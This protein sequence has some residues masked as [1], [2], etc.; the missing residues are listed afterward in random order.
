MTSLKELTDHE[1]SQ[2]TA[3]NWRPEIEIVWGMDTPEK[4][5][6]WDGFEP[7]EFKMTPGQKWQITT[8]TN[9]IFNSPPTYYL[10]LPGSQGAG[11]TIS[12]LLWAIAACQKGFLSP[13]TN[14]YEGWDHV[15]VAQTKEKL[16]RSLIKW[17]KDMMQD[18]G[19][20]DRRRW[21]ATNRIYTFENGSRMLFVSTDNYQK[22]MGERYHSFY[23]NELPG[24]ECETF[25]ALSGRGIVKCIA[26][27]NPKS[28]FWYEYEW[29]PKHD[30]YTEMRLAYFG[31]EMLYIVNTEEVK[32]LETM[33]V[34]DPGRYRTM[35]L[36]L[37]GATSQ[38]I[39][40][41]DPAEK[42]KDAKLICRGLDF[43][44]EAPMALINIYYKG[45]VYYVEEEIYLTSYALTDLCQYIRGLPGA[46]NVPIVCDSKRPEEI[47]VLRSYSLPATGSKVQGPYQK[48]PSINT[49]QEK[50]IYYTPESTNIARESRQYR[51]ALDKED[52][53]DYTKVAPSSDHAIDAIRYAICMFKNIVEVP[54]EASWDQS[55][56]NS[57]TWAED[58]MGIESVPESSDSFIEDT[59]DDQGT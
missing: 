32:R 19:V 47:D 17:F 51:W 21:N 6:A 49:I 36:G 18:G 13:L 31:N 22:I 41:W 43:G 12:V 34:K 10:M 39:L 37:T 3:D 20:Y 48:I 53:I 58:V 11:K 15:C 28:E 16:D 50:I 54:S 52:K 42:P 25:E 1:I 57:R 38:N 7:F 44:Y 9:Y 35:G 2:I 26:D 33:K 55:S 27:W 30:D 40:R 5:R 14:E 8:N 29:M 46:F 4:E 56:S 23:F 45:Q 24:I 59:M